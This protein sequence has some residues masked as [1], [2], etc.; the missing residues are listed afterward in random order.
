MITNKSREENFTGKDETSTVDGRISKGASSSSVAPW[1]RLR[2]PRIV[3]VSRASGGK[4]RHS[5]VCTVKGLRDRRVRLSVPTAIQLYDLQDRLG[6]NQP[7][8]AVDWLLNAAKHDIDELPPLQIPPGSFGEI[9]GSSLSRSERELG[10]QINH[11]VDWDDSLGLYRSN[12]CNSDAALRDKAKAIPIGMEDHKESWNQ[13]RN[14]EEKQLRDK[15]KAISIGMED[16]KESWNQTRNEEEKQGN[17]EGHGANVSS[18]GFFPKPNHSFIPG[19]LNN[20]APYNSL[21]RL[22]PSSFSSSQTEDFPNFNFVPLPS[23]SSSLSFGS[24]VLVCPPGI[25]QPYFP[26]SH[27][28][29]DPKQIN[30]FQILSSNSQNPLSNSPI[31]FVYSIGQSIRP[32]SYQD[33]VGS[34]SNNDVEFPPK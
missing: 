17:V 1:S 31:P 10:F 3:R 19:L 15:A 29:L 23:T 33:N 21:Y 28:E 13:T 20:V 25:A 9:H 7:S 5:K 18:T 14:E 34:Q 4:D 30:H 6:L 26:N 11:R 16:H 22:D 8:K 24:Q 12:F 2:D 27:V 32:L